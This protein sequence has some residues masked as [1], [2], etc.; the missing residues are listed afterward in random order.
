MFCW[1]ILAG[2][3]AHALYTFSCT[4]RASLFAL[5]ATLVAAVSV[6]AFYVLRFFHDDVIYRHARLSPPAHSP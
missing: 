6:G 4:R 5:A 2:L 3:V 1:L